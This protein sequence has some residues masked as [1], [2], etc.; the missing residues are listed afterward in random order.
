MFSPCT[1]QHISPEKRAL[2]VCCVCT[3]AGEGMALSPLEQTGQAA[4][5][6]ASLQPCF[7]L[8]TPA[9]LVTL[10]EGVTSHQ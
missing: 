6:E 4:P 1:S 10:L 3:D 7:R 5:R 2:S 8:L 9:L